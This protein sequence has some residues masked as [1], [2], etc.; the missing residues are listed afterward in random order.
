[1][2]KISTGIKYW[3]QIFLLPIYFLSFLFLRNKKIWIYGSSFGRRF[4][5][6]P[7]Y[8]YLYM[9]QHH[10]DEIRSIW[11]T[12]NKE[13]VQILQNHG[14]EAYV[15]YSFK[16]VFYSSIGGVYLYDNYTKDISF[17]LSGSA[18][19]I[20][21]WHGIP[22][23]KINMDNVY[24]KVRHPENMWSKVKYALRRMSDEKPSHYVVATSEFISDIFSSAFATKRVIISGY[25]RNDALISNIIDDFTTKDD[26]ALLWIA[27]KKNEGK[28]IITYMPT[29]R[30]SERRLFDI[31]NFNEFNHY[32]QQN[33]MVLCVKA[34]PKSV[35]K[36]TLKDMNVKNTLENI[37]VI[38]S[39]AD[40]YQILKETDCL[41][42]DY[43]SIYFDYLLLDRKIIFFPY[44]YE[45]YL[46]H[47]RE[48]Y[49]DYDSFTPGI[50]AYDMK[51]LEKALISSD[52][53]Q[54]KRLELKNRMFQLPEIISS[55]LLYTN[56]KEILNKCK[57]ER[58]RIA[59][60]KI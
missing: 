16:G 2:S 5:D 27:K 33:Q 54:E 47:S 17:W 41:I 37:F 29:F 57:V 10:G 11:I 44:D 14:Y 46:S 3:L 42:T 24:D 43:S 6:S 32:L 23:K 36:Q 20:N 19:K 15:S 8:F 9:N 49:F 38:D 25:P 18:K 21:L 39:I 12:K 26:R 40:P 13:L 7:K 30:E 55:E 59:E 34:H 60:K 50:K 1:M 52:N 28:K 58:K 35:I 53:Y 48:L 45:E 51:G 4:A 22:L 31:I 56:M